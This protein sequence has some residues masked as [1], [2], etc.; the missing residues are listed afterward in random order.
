MRLAR[1]LAL[2]IFDRHRRAMGWRERL[3]VWMFG[4]SLCLAWSLQPTI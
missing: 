4:V 3:T 2:R 1:A